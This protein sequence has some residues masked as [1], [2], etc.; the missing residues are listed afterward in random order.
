MVIKEKVEVSIDGKYASIEPN[1]LFQIS[2]EIDFRHPLIG[3]QSMSFEFSCKSYIKEIC[4]A[5]T[6]GMLSDVD[7]L[8]KKGLVKG[9]SL[10]NAI[11]L[12]D[13][14]VLNPEGLRFRDEFN[15]HKILDTIGDFSLLGYAIAGKLKT[16]KSGHFLNNLLCL[17]VLK[18]SF[19]L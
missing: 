5:R 11:V 10:D 15:R 4:R 13:F 16:V 6:F 7:L 12:D 18:K 3:K 14:K 19:I 2:S 17:E 1:P 8:K 9:G